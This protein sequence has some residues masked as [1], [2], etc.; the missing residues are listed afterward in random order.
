[1]LMAL[2]FSSVALS[3][4]DIWHFS[5][6]V[7]EEKRPR[8]SVE[9]EP[10]VFP[11]VSLP[12]LLYQVSISKRQAAHRWEEEKNHQ[13]NINIIESFWEAFLSCRWNCSPED[14]PAYCLPPTNQST[15]TSPSSF[16]CFLSTPLHLRTSLNLSGIYCKCPT[17]SL[18]GVAVA[19]G[20]HGP[21][22][23]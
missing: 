16:P 19:C 15:S 3:S 6:K 12:V 14:L 11:S 23:I 17:L 7:V 8:V 2:L 9:K 20:N 5:S 4:A 21:A 13:H 18:V 22:G 1:M 10:C